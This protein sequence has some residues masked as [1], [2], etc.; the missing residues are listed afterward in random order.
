MKK[1]ARKKQ[2]VAVFAS[3]GKCRTLATETRE[4]RWAGTNS[5]LVLIELRTTTPG[6]NGHRAKHTFRFLLAVRANAGEY[7]LEGRWKTRG[8]AERAADEYVRNATKPRRGRTEVT[9]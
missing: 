2:P 8:A 5:P 7:P 6:E 9:L 3:R 1:P 4:R